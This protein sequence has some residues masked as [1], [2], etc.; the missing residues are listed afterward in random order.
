MGEGK[1]SPILRRLMKK[2]LSILTGLIFIVP[3]HAQVTASQLMGLGMNAELASLVETIPSSYNGVIATS[4]LPTTVGTYDVGSL[5]KT[6]DQV[7]Q[8]KVAIDADVTAVTGAA[9]Y[10]GSK[11]ASSDAD[12]L[13]LVGYGANAVGVQLKGFK[14]RATTTDANTIVNASDQL[15]ALTAYGSDGASYRAAGN[16]T[17]NVDGTPGSSDMPGNIVFQ[18]SPDGSATPATALTIANTKDATFTGA[19]TSASTGSLGWSYVTGANTACT[20]T[21][22]SAAVFGVDLAA[23]ASA[24]VI[25]GPSA[26]TADACVCAGAS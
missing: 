7:F 26:A 20:T 10:F 1:S 6:W 25:V 8:G 14:T 17:F 3:A 4:L 19:V 24:P 15:L 23:G 12:Q 9:G 13:A 11:N 18:V 21:C 2:I 16:I 5:T 22:T